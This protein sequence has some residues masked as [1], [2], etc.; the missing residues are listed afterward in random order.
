MKTNLFYLI[1]F[2]LN[3]Q[4]Y[5]QYNEL[6]WSDEFDLDSIDAGKWNFEIGNGVSGWGNSESEYYTNRPENA[7]IENGKLIIT[8]LLEN[9]GG[10]QYTSA[11]LQTKNKG[12]WKYGR[13]EMMAKL[14]RGK[15]TWPAFWMMPQQQTYGTNLWPDN[16][17]IDIMEYVG[18]IP[19]VIYGTVHTNKNHGANGVSKSVSY[20]GIENDFHKFAIE[21]SPDT[22]KWFVDSIEY[23]TY[24]RS[25]RNW[26]YW[27]FDMDF[28]IIINLAIG[29]NWGGTQGID[30]AIFPQTYE[31]EY[32]R[33]Y[34]TLTADIIVNN[35]DSGHIYVSPNPVKDKLKIYVKDDK[36]SATKIS[37]Y[38]LNGNMIVSPL[39]CKS[40]HTDIDFSKLMSGVYIVLFQ[41]NEQQRSYKIIKL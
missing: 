6:I 21:W 20:S 10:F 2:F 40:Q 38:D 32:I 30:N 3:I 39:P 34:Q 31:I 16:G 19:G 12:H 11:R 33:V 14:P 15:G 36:A 41:N 22:I 35:W 17:E 4:T 26:Q 5:G 29:G 25:F 18:Y 28:Y 27:P 9:Y 37:V 1:L 7:K 23:A 13:I 24:L 8:A